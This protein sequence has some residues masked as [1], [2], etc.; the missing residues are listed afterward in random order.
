VCRPE[1]AVFALI[2]VIGCGRPAEH[3]VVQHVDA[4]APVA[5]TA[6]VRASFEP[7]HPGWEVEADPNLVLVV[8]NRTA[9]PYRMNRFVATVLPLAIEGVDEH[10]ARIPLGPPPMPREFGEADFATIAPGGSERFP[11]SAQVLA[12]LPKGRYHLV[13]RIFPS[14]TIDF[15]TP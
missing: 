3:V 2:L 1:I 6:S 4:V 8:E 12:R 9:S 7:L 13:S 11:T 5:E 14:A 15:E 10:G